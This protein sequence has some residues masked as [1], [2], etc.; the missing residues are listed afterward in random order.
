MIRRQATTKNQADTRH[1]DS[2]G[3]SEAKREGTRPQPNREKDYSKGTYLRSAAEWFLSLISPCLSSSNPFEHRRAQAPPRRWIGSGVSRWSTPG[4]LAPHISRDRSGCLA[5][6][7][8]RGMAMSSLVRI[9]V[10]VIQSGGMR[11][12]P[13]ARVR[14]RRR[15]GSRR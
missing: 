14:P 11:A 8:R 5:G 15:R 2:R 7:G 1:R 6:I 13:A 4:W 12:T 3:T 10:V 9:A